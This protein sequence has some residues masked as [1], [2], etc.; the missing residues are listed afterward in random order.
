MLALVACL[1][2]VPPPSAAPAEV[3]RNFAEHGSRPNIIVF[4]TDD[5][6]YELWPTVTQ[7]T[8]GLPNNYSALLRS[9]ASEFVSGGLE[10]DHMYT[11]ELSF[12]SRRSLLSG[13]YMT[14]AGVPYGRVNSLTT[15]I[16]TLAD[17]LKAAGYSNHFIGKWALGYSHPSTLPTRRGFD[18]ALGFHGQSIQQ[19]EWHALGFNSERTSLGETIYDL[20]ISV[21]AGIKLVAV[22]A[23]APVPVLARPESPH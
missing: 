2:T 7:G 22:P 20:I 21:H 1:S 23:P 5:W 14:S 19:Y 3:S 6:P 10:V 18:T 16:S 17:R 4:F 13:R 11:H 8:S 12:P 9:L 15:R